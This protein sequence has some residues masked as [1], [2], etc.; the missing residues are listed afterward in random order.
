VTLDELAE[1]FGQSAFPKPGRKRQQKRDILPVDIYAAADGTPIYVGKSGKGNALLTFSI[2][3]GNDYWFHAKDYAGAHVVLRSGR[4]S[5][6]QEAM[7]DA[8]AL[9]AHFSKA[10][11]ARAVDVSCTQIKHVTRAR[12]GPDGAV[13]ISAEK[14]VRFLRDEARMR[15]LLATRKRCEAH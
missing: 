11:D 3:S 14:T 2:A 9:A 4:K 12:G 5:P 8:A 10:R 7:L 6:S 15:R 1:S 13:F